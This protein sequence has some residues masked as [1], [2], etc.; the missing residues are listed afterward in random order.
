MSGDSVICFGVG[1]GMAS[2]GRNHSAFLY[3]MGDT[4]LLLDCGEPVGRSYQACGAGPDALDA[5]L[6]SHLH[7][8]H[9]GGFFMLL[10]GIMLAGRRRSLP[11][12]LNRWGR[13]PVKNLVE[14]ALFWN[15]L[16]AFELDFRTLEARQ[17]IEVKDVKITPFPTTHLAGQKEA[18]PGKP[19]PA[20]ESFAFLLESAEHRIVHSS[21][22]GAP[23]DLDPWLEQPVDLL[24]CELAHFRPEVLFDYLQGKAVKRLALVHLGRDCWTR[25]NEIH[26]F[27][28]GSLPDTEICIPEDGDTFFLAARG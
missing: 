16:P 14:A 19:D 9:L 7:F 17:P 18:L 6:I 4:T 15:E 2:V 24:V 22:L 28:G 21:D 26:E 8:D 27:A 12:F 10:Q 3:K 13:D 23:G 1:D 20:F 11:V 5:V 25:R